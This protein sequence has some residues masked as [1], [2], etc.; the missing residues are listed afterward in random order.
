MST[1]LE[2]PSASQGRANGSEGKVADDNAKADLE[3]TVTDEL[4]PADVAVII[5]GL[6]ARRL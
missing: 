4:A 3:I 5:D 2:R 6:G 1:T